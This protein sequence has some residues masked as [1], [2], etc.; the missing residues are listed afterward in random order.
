MY[1]IVKLRNSD[2]Y[3]CNVQDAG[4]RFQLDRTCYPLCILRWQLGEQADREIRNGV[5]KCQFQH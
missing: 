5:L 4:Y 1:V 2:L 3:V